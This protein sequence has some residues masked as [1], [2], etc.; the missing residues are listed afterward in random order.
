MMPVK[1]ES[2]QPVVWFLMAWES[3]GGSV[4]VF[5]MLGFMDERELRCSP[6]DPLVPWRIFRVRRGV[7][8]CQLSAPLIHDPGYER[9]PSRAIDARC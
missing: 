3:P 9:F 6:E 4:A 5:G 7:D 2:T 8:G 1:A